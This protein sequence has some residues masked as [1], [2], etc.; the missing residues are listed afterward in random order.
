MIGEKLLEQKPLALR[1]V[2]EMLEA[3]KAER[4]LSY[5]QDIALKHAKKFVKLKE[6]KEKKLFEDLEKLGVLS[7]EEIVKIIN[8]LPERKEIIPLI[9]PKLESEADKIFEV[10]SK[11]VKKK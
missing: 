9:S 2:R 4:E 10:V 11:Y 1:E 7:E 6:D 3:R 8:I 5:E